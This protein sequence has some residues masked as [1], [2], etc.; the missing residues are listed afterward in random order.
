LVFENLATFAAVAPAGPLAALDLGTKTI[1]LAVSDVGRT[2]ANPRR[3]I[4]RTRFTADAALLM[5]AFQADGVTGIVVGLPLNMDGSEG[6]RAQSCRA[7][8]RNFERLCP[9]PWCFADERL[10]TVA[11]SEALHEAGFS[12]RRQSGKIDSAAA[13][14]ILQAVLERLPRQER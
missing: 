3:V 13:A 12:L 14:V 8:M 6:P 4:Q 1:G 7:F 10:S 5:K 9:L 11:A 2:L